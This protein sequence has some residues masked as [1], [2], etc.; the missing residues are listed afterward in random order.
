MIRFGSLCSPLSGHLNPT[1]ALCH[2]LKARGHEVT[3]LS[4]ADAQSKANEAGI[5]FVA[6]G[7]LKFPMGSIKKELKRIGEISGFYA[8]IH[9]L[10]LYK[11]LTKVML[12]YAPE[13]IRQTQVD[14]L[15]IDQSLL[16]GS[17]IAE[18]L[19]LPFVTLCNA[20]MLDP[21]PNVPPAL[22]PWNYDPTWLGRIRNQCGNKFFELIGFPLKN[23]LEDFRRQHNL[24]VAAHPSFELVNSSL[25]II[26]QQPREFEFPRFKLPPHFHFV[27]SLVNSTTRAPVDFPMERL[28][29]QPLIY[30]S[31][32]T[33][34]NSTKRIFRE[35]AIACTGLDVQ[36]VISL[37]GF[38]STEELGEMPGDPI[39][40]N[41]AP[42]LELL[43]RASLSITHAGLNT[44]LESLRCGVPMVAIP[45]ANDQPAIAARIAWTK[46]GEV[47]PL[48]RLNTN[49][50]RSVIKRVLTE[51]FY[52]NNALNLQTAIEKAGGVK[53][54]ADIVEKAIST[55]KPVYRNQKTFF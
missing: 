7:E 3:L 46:T 5:N 34:Q 10:D 53:K 19:K 30:A 32:G 45:I 13:K 22:T 35:I 52:K 20:L 8:T 21:D 25:S 39:V 47:I 28:T 48:N 41:Y 9:T 38:F 55:K 16:E 15:I 1:I 14:A 12:A 44:V 24:P 54:A 33:I 4:T 17:T 31:L 50:L 6:I 26:S 18:L 49:H 36:L 27:G 42:Q 37:G 11:R 43:K 2:E 51:K 29:G 40:V 23:I